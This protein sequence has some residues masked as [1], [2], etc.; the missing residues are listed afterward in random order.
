MTPISL[1]VCMYIPTIVAVLLLRKSYTAATNT[2][3]TTEEIV[4]A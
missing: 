1:R 3:P 2:H 4:D